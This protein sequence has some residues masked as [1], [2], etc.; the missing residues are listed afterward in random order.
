MYLVAESGRAMCT[1]PQLLLPNLMNLSVLKELLAACK[2][3]KGLV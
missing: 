3:G 2:G 1:L